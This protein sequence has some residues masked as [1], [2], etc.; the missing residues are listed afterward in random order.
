MAPGRISPE[1]PN[2][3]GLEDYTATKKPTVYV[4]DKFHPKAIEHA[5]TLFSVVLNTDPEFANWQEKATAILMRGSYLRADDIAKCPRLIAIGKH[6]VG[7][8]KIDQEACAARNIKICNTPGA[9]AQAV[10]EIVL[11]LSMAVARQI[12]SITARQMRAP[13]P[14]ETCNGITLYG[15]TLGVIGMGNI[16]LKVAR[17]FQRA[18]DAPILAF[19]PYMPNDA[20]PDVPHTRVASYHDL[21]ATSDVLTIH[22]PLTDETRDMI[23]AK[24]LK[25]MKPSAILINASRGGIVNEKD[26]EEALRDGTT[27]GAGLDAHEEE[28][29]TVQRYGELWKLPNVVSTPHI[30]AATDDA[31]LMSAMGAVDNLYAHLK[32]LQ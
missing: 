10:A 7:I 6:G 4:I 15:K 11:A 20:W 14:K 9:N 21:L 12:P 8:D 29:P 17:M 5:R 3:K 19:D 31:Q 26:L 27:W 1:A 24:E 16:G 30:G 22:V 18:F 32:S 28:P 2:T 25:Q 23:A 13:V